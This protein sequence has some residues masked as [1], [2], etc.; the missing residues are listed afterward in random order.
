MKHL[1]PAFFAAF[2]AGLGLGALLPRAQD[3]TADRLT[4]KRRGETADVCIVPSKGG[5]LLVT[6]DGERQSVQLQIADG[7]A[8]VVIH[9]R[10]DKRAVSLD[11]DGLHLIDAKGGAKEWP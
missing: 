7:E 3:I 5:D 9:G 8:S 11:L 2:A 10:D 4:V 1:L 6:L